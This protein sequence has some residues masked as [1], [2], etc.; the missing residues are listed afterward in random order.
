M[1]LPSRNMTIAL[2]GDDATLTEVYGYNAIIRT[3]DQQGNLI[4]TPNPETLGQHVKR[5]IET[6]V[7]N[8]VRR[9]LMT[10]AG[11]DAEA[12]KAVEIAD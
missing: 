6:H 9:Y 8:R 3:R 2:K 12:A 4:E 1:P 5:E 10:K 7:N 11:S